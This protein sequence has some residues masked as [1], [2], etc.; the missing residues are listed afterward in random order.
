MNELVVIG[1]EMDREALIREF[2]ACL[3]SDEELASG[4]EAWA[5]TSDDFGDSDLG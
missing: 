2:H 1:V 3:L 4:K 5:G